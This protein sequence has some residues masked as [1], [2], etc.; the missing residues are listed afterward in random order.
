MDAIAASLRRFWSR[1]PATDK[2]RFRLAG[3]ALGVLLTAAF[4]NTHIVM[5]VREARLASQAKQNLH[6][7]QLAV[8]RFAVDQADGNYPLRASEVIAAGYL[9][10]MPPNPYTG[11]PMQEYS[12]DTQLLP[13]GDFVYYPRYSVAGEATDAEVIGYTL[14]L[15]QAGLASLRESIAQERRRVEAPF[16][17]RH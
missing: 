7:V 4:V 12:V 13:A 1:V 8:E 9:S 5:P 11:Q 16:P 14:A 3:S 2:L 15:G 6:A 17:S 10:V